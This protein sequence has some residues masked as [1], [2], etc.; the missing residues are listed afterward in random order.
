MLKLQKP[1]STIITPS[2]SS[3]QKT[4]GVLPAT[5]AGSMYVNFHVIPKITGSLPNATVDISQMRHVDHPKL[6]NLNFSVPGKIDVL[7]GADIIEDLMLDNRIREK[8]LI[9]RESLLCWIIRVQ[10]W[11]RVV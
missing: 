10:Y 6:A 3:S 8:G 7:V 5:I 4:C 11:R 9:L 2:A 1:P